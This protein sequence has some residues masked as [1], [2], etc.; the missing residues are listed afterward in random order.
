M[1]FATF[2][3]TVQPNFNLANFG[4][5]TR[6]DSRNREQPI[7]NLSRDAFALV[8]MGFT[9]RKALEWKIKYIQ[10]FNEMEAEIQR[11]NMREGKIE[12]LKLFPDLKETV[13]T[14]RSILTTTAAISLIAYFNL[15]IPPVSGDQLRRLLKKGTVEGFFDGHH[16]QIYQD[17][18]DAWLNLRRTIRCQSRLI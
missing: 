17:S 11:R 5:I 3:P 6:R 7:F 13:D 15:N 18:F 16:W 14:S 1:I 4:E 9:G 2:C 8:A 12:Q 10:A